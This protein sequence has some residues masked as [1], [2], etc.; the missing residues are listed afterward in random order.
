VPFP[1][2]APEGH[3][4]RVFLGRPLVKYLKTK[5]GDLMNYLRFDLKVIDGAFRA[6]LQ[7]R[8]Y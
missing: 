7:S 4:T 6:H 5:I 2:L 8:Q 3:C 1:K